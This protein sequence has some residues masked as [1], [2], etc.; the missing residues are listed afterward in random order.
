MTYMSRNPQLA[1]VVL[2]DITTTTPGN[3]PSGKHK[4]V[5]RNG[6][7]FIRDASGAEVALGTTASV[8]SGEKNYI[9]NPSGAAATTGWET[10]GDLTLSRTTTASEL[11]RENTTKTGIKIIADADTQ[12][13]G[14]I[15]YFNFTLDDVDLGRFMKI[16]FDLKK[17]ATYDGK[18]QCYVAT[19]AD[20]A[21]QVAG[22]AV[23]PAISGFT[24]TAIPG[25][26]GTFTIYF[27]SGSTAALSLV[28]QAS[29]DMT[30]GD[31]ITISDVVVGPNVQVQGS[32][33]GAWKSFSPTTTW[34][35]NVNWTGMYREVG[36][37]I[38]CMVL[39]EVTG[40]PTSADLQIDIPS[41]FTIDTTKLPL[42]T[43]TSELS[44]GT[45]QLQDTGTRW[46]TGGVQYN[47]TNT[48]RISHSDSGN[49]GIVNATAPFT[50]ANTDRVGVMFTLPVNELSSN[51][52][53]A[54][55]AVEEYAAD[56]GSAD[57]FGPN[58]ALVP[59]QAAGTSTTRTFVYSG[60]MESTD[61]FVLEF[62]VPETKAWSQAPVMDS[63]SGQ[64]I[65]GLCYTNASTNS[66]GSAVKTNGTSKTISVYFGKSAAG[67]ADTGA[68]LVAWS[69]LYSAGWRYR[70]RKVSGG[71]S[72][73]YP[74]SSANIVGRTDGVAPAAG[75]VGERQYQTVAISTAIG[76]SATSNNI[77]SVS[78]TAGVWLISA[79]GYLN[80]GGGTYVDIAISTT[81]SSSGGTFGYSRV[82][83]NGTYANPCIPSVY[84]NISS[85]TTY[86]L[87]A[88]GQAIGS[89]GATIQAVR[90]A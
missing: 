61:F 9:S 10:Y 20:V 63:T 16:K 68:S 34:V 45:S 22:G 17:L 31:G 81:T 27:V 72:V 64:V 44:L 36:G 69:A 77:A 32:A 66:F 78:L 82:Q 13:T 14:D 50:W 83:T 37:S 52:T 3:P 90:I 86:Y 48:V 71:A 38:E 58:G 5:D 70:L 87:C 84:V 43:T 59:N 15:V 89:L 41:G 85:T 6:T 2:D 12:G 18:L 7:M 29:A 54:N 11:P 49:A 56:D 53:L 67:Y 19:A 55:R 8:G 25:T 75:M 76:T 79:V 30:T 57:V 65:Q 1:S 73:G 35:S 42:S 28:I 26:D 33:I 80:S 46:F 62:N 4:L 23:A 51:V 21:T 47:D 39:G 88:Y 60:S 40:A 24:T 74:I